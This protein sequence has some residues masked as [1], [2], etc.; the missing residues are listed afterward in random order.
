MNKLRSVVAALLLA[1][2]PAW[3]GPFED[4]LAAAVKGDYATALRLLQPLAGSGNAD[5]QLFLGLVYVN[6]EGVP[7]DDQQAL[8]WLRK[9]ADQG[10]ASA[11]YN[12]GVMYRNG[13]GV[14]K[15]DQQAYFWWL[16]ASVSGHAEAV[17]HRDLV[18]TRLTP[19]QRAAAQADA[20]TWKPRQP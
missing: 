17:K 5:A 2:M 1:A 4:A 10:N 7:K 3:A 20:R 13:R 19:Q 16:L 6:G 14:P 12:L 9:S 15:D 8:H 11:Q 18:E